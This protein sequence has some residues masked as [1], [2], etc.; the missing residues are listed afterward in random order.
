MVDNSTQSPVL[1]KTQI[2]FIHLGLL[3]AVEDGQDVRRTLA[4]PVQKWQKV[5]DQPEA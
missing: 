1:V 3:R 5:R 4:T 2:I